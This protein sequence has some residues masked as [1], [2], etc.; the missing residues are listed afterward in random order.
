[1]QIH[2]I[3]NTGTL[4]QLLDRVLRTAGGMGKNKIICLRATHDKLELSVPGALAMTK[5][6]VHGEGDIILPT[7]LLKA[8]LST[9][10]TAIISFTFK[11]GEIQCGSSIITTSAIDII[12]LGLR[13]HLEVPINSSRKS[14]TRYALTE[15]DDINIS[16]KGM[17]ATIKTAKMTLKADIQSALKFLE[18]YDMTHDDLERLIMEKL[19]KK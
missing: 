4:K 5:A 9:C 17:G 14:L 13:P 10:S 16:K 12:P 11:K 18:K 2:F 19:V 8:Y 1:M 7:K 3:V 6:E 15:Q